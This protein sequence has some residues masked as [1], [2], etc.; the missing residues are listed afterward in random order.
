MG[1]EQPGPGA[2][3]TASQGPSPEGKAEAL[4]PQQAKQLPRSQAQSTGTQGSA[5]TYFAG[6]QAV[7]VGTGVAGSSGGPRTAEWLLCR[8]VGADRTR[9]AWLMG[10]T[11]HCRPAGAL[12]TLGLALVPTL[13]LDVLREPSRVGSSPWPAHG[14]QAR[15]EFPEAQQWETAG[16]GSRPWAWPL[17]LISGQGRPRPPLPSTRLWGAQNPQ[18][19]VLTN[20]SLPAWFPGRSVQSSPYAPLSQSSLQVPV[21]G[22]PWKPVS[23]NPHS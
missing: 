17:D 4:A 20:T 13:T 23:V 14:S 15:S 11:A 2:Q 8:S 6:A 3:G 18:G 19:C 21:L 7:G 22:P 5:P 16:W 1:G 12:R 10:A 9:S